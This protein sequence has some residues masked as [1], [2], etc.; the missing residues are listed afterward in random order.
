MKR[1]HG[2][3]E[4]AYERFY[5]LLA[6][7][8]IAALVA[9]N[10]IFQKFF[11]WEISLFGWGYTFQLSVGILPYP[12]TSLVIDILSEVY[13]KKTERSSSCVDGSAPRSK[14]WLRRK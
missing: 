8:F 12:I 9:C 5:L 11:V 10:L 6:A 4:P 3:Y 13:G 2:Q 7:I 1:H 14:R